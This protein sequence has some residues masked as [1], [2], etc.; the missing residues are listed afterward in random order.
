MAQSY[1]ACIQQL[2]RGLAACG[3]NMQLS[4]EH[5]SVYVL[6]DPC[7]FGIMGAAEVARYLD[8][9]EEIRP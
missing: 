6:G 9:I 3:K 8:E 1:L 7:P 4:I 5:G 2:Q